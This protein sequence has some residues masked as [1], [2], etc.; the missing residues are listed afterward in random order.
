MQP[1][2]TPL[3]KGASRQGL[4]LIF[5]RKDRSQRAIHILP[6]QLLQ[7]ERFQPPRRNLREEHRRIEEWEV[8]KEML[9]RMRDAFTRQPAGLQL[10]SAAASA[11]EEAARRGRLATGAYS[12]TNRLAARTRPVA[13][14]NSATSR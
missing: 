3:T 2:V 10:L 1:Q 9:G 7:V 12:T 5:D 8:A 4:S 11:N 13:W 6:L 14:S